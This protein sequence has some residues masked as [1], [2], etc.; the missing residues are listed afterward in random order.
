MN[1]ETLAACEKV[2]MLPG[3]G[4]VQSLNFAV[5]FCLRILTVCADA[6]LPAANPCETF[7]KASLGAQNYQYGELPTLFDCP[8]KGFHGGGILVPALTVVT[9][10]KIDA[11]LGIIELHEVYDGISNPNY[12]PVPRADGVR[13]AMG[14]EGTLGCGYFKTLRLRGSALEELPLRRIRRKT[15]ARTFLLRGGD[16]WAAPSRCLIAHAVRSRCAAPSR[17][18]LRISCNRKSRCVARFR[19]RVAA[20]LGRV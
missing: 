11:A 1:A 13:F 18:P 16:R 3:F 20:E 17:R 8:N 12:A 14:W 9:G 6:D 4:R 19:L 7:G 10:K 2:A 15:I 5:I